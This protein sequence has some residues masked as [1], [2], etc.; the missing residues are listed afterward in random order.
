MLKD[1]YQIYVSI[2]TF[3][4]YDVHRLVSKFIILVMCWKYA[5]AFN[6]PYR[7][8]RLWYE[9]KMVI[10]WLRSSSC[11]HSIN[12]VYFVNHLFGNTLRTFIFGMFITFCFSNRPATLATFRNAIFSFHKDKIDYYV[13]GVGHISWIFVRYINSIH[14]NFDF[15]SMHCMNCLASVRPNYA[16]IYVSTKTINSL[17]QSNQNHKLISIRAFLKVF[18]VHHIRYVPCSLCLYISLCCEM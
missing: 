3:I 5:A 6:C 10:K 7:M 13:Q 8:K 15:E 12:G 14:M 17:G 18:F 16:I 2:R 9:K 4:I 11:V 1:L